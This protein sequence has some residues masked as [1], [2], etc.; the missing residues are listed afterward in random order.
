MSST[1]ANAGGQIEAHHAPTSS[2]ITRATTPEDR[3]KKRALVVGL[4]MVGVAFIEKLIKADIDNGRDEWEIV[5]F[6]EEVSLT[7]LRFTRGYR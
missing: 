3:P 4:G 2:D 6:G 5:V 1:L 7:P